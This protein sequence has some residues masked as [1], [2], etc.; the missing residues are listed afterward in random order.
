MSTGNQSLINR[1]Q[2][3]ILL[4]M[5]L[6]AEMVGMDMSG[7]ATVIAQVELDFHVGLVTAQWM[8]NIYALSFGVSIVTGG[9]LGDLFGHR[10][11]LLIGLA[12]FGLTSLVI[13]FASTAWVAVVARGVQGLGGA[14]IWPSIV[15]IAF[16]S[17]H[18]QV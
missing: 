6:A 13:V 3:W 8:L 4:I 10:K 7:V 15:A 12:I 17:G 16:S 9:K 2:L 1:H 5:A 11:N 14:L 18:C